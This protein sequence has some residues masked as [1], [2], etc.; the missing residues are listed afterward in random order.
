MESLQVKTVV[1]WMT[2]SFG[3]RLVDNSGEV[4][5]ERPGCFDFDPESEEE[6]LDEFLSHFG[7][8]PWL[9]VREVF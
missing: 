4:L 3:E 2:V 7:I 5:Y 6:A 8:L 9:K 1:D